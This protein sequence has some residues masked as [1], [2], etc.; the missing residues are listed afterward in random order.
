MAVSHIERVA[1]SGDSIQLHLVKS[2]RAGPWSEPDHLYVA[3][4]GCQYALRA[5]GRGEGWTSVCLIHRGN[6]RLIESPEARDM[7]HYGVSVAD[8]LAENHSAAFMA[9]LVGQNWRPSTFEYGSNAGDYTSELESREG[10]LWFHL[11]RQGRA[12]RSV[13]IAVRGVD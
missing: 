3:S 12:M 1:P 13:R 11:V 9:F 7:I 5:Y 6:I 4:C 8:Y 2:I 10:E